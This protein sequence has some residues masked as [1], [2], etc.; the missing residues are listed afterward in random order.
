MGKA[1]KQKKALRKAAH[2][3]TGFTDDQMIANQ[4]DYIDRFV[5]CGSAI[6]AM[7]KGEPND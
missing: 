5:E 7:R 3:A 6:I 4:A 2:F 1:R